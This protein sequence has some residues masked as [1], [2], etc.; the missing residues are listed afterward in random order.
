M[1][2]KIKAST[3]NLAMWFFYKTCFLCD[4]IITQIFFLH[5]NFVSFEEIYNLPLGIGLLIKL[6]IFWENLCGPK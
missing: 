5:L 6:Q 3:V 4:E 2:E 1:L